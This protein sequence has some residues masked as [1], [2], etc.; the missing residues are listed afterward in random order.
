[1]LVV[2]DRIDSEDIV[3]REQSFN[4][5]DFIWP[6]ITSCTEEIFQKEDK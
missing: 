5:N 2:E 6:G 3:T 1:M 4:I